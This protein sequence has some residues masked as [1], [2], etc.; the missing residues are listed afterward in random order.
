MRSMDFNFKL[1]FDESKKLKDYFGELFDQT[2]EAI[3]A[4]ARHG[5]SEAVN[6][7]KQKTREY[8]ASSPFRSDYSKQYPVGLIE[9]VRA[10][11][12]KDTPT[13]FVHVKGTNKHIEGVYG[14]DGTWRLRFFEVGTRRGI[15][16]YH[17]LNDAVGTL[18]SDI[19]NIIQKSIQEKIDELNR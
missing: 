14:G 18:G 2:N 1:G 3:M 17:F 19:T 13:G 5:V 7:L 8:V 15:K 10:Y 9:G 16:A 6:A 11:M 12:M 4:G